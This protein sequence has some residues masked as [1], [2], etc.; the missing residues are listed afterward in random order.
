VY[1][2][3][4][5]SN[6][7]RLFDHRS[8]GC[9]D[10][11]VDLKTNKPISILMFPNVANAQLSKKLKWRI[12]NND[13]SF[14]QLKLR[15]QVEVDAKKTLEKAPINGEHIHVQVCRFKSLEGLLPKSH[16]Q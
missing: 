2:G 11:R 14:I 5:W 6:K 15:I 16:L 3:G 4:E 8:K 13:V 10:G 1:Y 12:K 9:L 7:L